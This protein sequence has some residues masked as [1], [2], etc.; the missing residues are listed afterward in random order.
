MPSSSHRTPIDLK[1][2]S[3]PERTKR[4]LNKMNEQDEKLRSKLHIEDE[5]RRGYE[6]IV[7]S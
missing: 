1:P 7:H 5:R 3:M 2:F 4:W 6:S